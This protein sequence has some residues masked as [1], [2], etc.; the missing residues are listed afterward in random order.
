M[1]TEQIRNFADEFV[2]LGSKTEDG[3]KL[4]LYIRANNLLHAMADT[5]D[6][7]QVALSASLDEAN[8][9][10]GAF[11]AGD[12]S[13][14]EMLKSIKMWLEPIGDARD[15]MKEILGLTT[16]EDIIL[17]RKIE[18]TITLDQ[19]NNLL[20][21]NFGSIEDAVEALEE[22]NE[23]EELIIEAM[24]REGEVHD[25]IGAEMLAR[26]DLQDFIIDQ[27]NI[28]VGL[29]DDQ[30]F[31]LF[32]VH[33]LLMNDMNPEMGNASAFRAGGV[34]VGSSSQADITNSIIWG[35]TELGVANEDAQFFVSADA[36]LTINNSIVQGWTGQYGGANNSGADP[37]FVQQGYWE[38]P[39]TPEELGDDVWFEGDH[40]V[41]PGS[42]GI[43]AGDNDAPFVWSP[44]LDGYPRILCDTV[45]IGPYEFGI[46]DDNCDGI[47]DLTDFS[48][49]ER[50]MTGPG[51]ANHPFGCEA[52]DFNADDV[53]DL[54][55]FAGF[56]SAFMGAGE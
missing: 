22:E 39:G 54:S 20:K 13:A 32:K 51:A 52:F 12:G 8:K 42:P 10:P 44:D 41:L 4:G 3:F 30:K 2:T 43:N 17:A 5:S 29:T 50:C 38:D 40:H 55:D 34:Y 31:A 19:I 15:L 53:I 9:L 35:N 26:A 23:Q 49:W 48:R 1:S 14:K 47:V 28:L 46:G 11:D 21:T 37:L 16:E 6:E 24:G 7:F 56:Q 36:T 33:R 45:D 25:A 27:G 18:E